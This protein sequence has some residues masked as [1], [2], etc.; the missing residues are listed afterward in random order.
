[1]EITTLLDV[2]GLLLVAAGLAA[3]VFPLIG[4]GSLAV[5]GAAVLGGSHLAVRMQRKGSSR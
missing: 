1:M 3:L 4:W 5:A 2:L